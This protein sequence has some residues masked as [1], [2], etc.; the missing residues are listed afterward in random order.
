[1]KSR[2]VE[3]SASALRQSS[4]SW[5]SLCCVFSIDKRGASAACRNERADPKGFDTPQQAAD[6][7]IKAAADF[8]VPELLAILGPDGHDLVASGGSGPGQEQR[9]WLSRKRPREEL[10][11]NR[12][13]R[14]RTAPPSLSAK[15]SGRCRFR[16]SRRMASGTST[17]RKDGRKFSFAASARMNSTP[18]TSVAAYVSAQ[19]E[20]ASANSRR[21]RSQPVRAEDHQ[22]S[23]Q[24]G[25]AVLEEC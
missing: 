14:I 3:S 1:M 25:W 8:D 17:P 2:N 13:S 12:P 23:R 10:D 5:C 20:Y 7:L 4:S 15:K 21:L 19:K 11:R 24:A 16:S 22:H 6:A 18:F 9:R